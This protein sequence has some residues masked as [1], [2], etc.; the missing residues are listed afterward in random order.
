MARTQDSTMQR[1]VAKVRAAFA[2]GL[3]AATLS[4][5]IGVAVF[6]AMAATM[7][8]AAG[9]LGVAHG[10]CQSIEADL[11]DDLGISTAT[12]RAI[13]PPLLDERIAARRAA[14]A[15]TPS[16]ARRSGERAVAYANCRQTFAAPL[17]VGEVE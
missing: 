15:L 2:A 10:A 5:G 14:G 6:G 12:L 4:L 16:A 11:A 3:V 8:V 1:I 7:T 17:V 13:E 9:G